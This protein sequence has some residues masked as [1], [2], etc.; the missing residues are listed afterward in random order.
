MRGIVSGSTRMGEK[1]SE[2]RPASSNLSFLH[3]K[4]KQGLALFVLDC[5]KNGLYSL[6]NSLSLCHHKAVTMFC[7]F[8][9]FSVR[10]FDNDKGD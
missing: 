1:E 4:K 5:L 2:L 7:V 3:N 9:D 10:K 6:P 8:K